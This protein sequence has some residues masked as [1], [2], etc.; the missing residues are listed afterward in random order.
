MRFKEICN[1]LIEVVIVSKERN[2]LYSV[3]LVAIRNGDF[4][5]RQTLIHVTIKIELIPFLIKP[6]SAGKC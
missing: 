1:Y 5:N 2:G 3:P 4:F 6:T